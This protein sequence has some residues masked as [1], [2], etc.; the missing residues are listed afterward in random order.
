MRLQEGE[1]AVELEP[2]FSPGTLLLTHYT[3]RVLTT[4]PRERVWSAGTAPDL[5]HAKHMAA[6]ALARLKRS[7]LQAA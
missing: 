1:Y 5:E 4:V 3:Y 2:E 7:R 6:A